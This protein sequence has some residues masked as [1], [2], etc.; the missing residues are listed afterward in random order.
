M[1]LRKVGED[2][3]TEKGVLDGEIQMLMTP[4]A[5]KE[6]KDLS[7]TMQQ[8]LLRWQDH[9]DLVLGDQL[10][11]ELKD[12]LLDIYEK[13]NKF[14]C[15]TVTD[16]VCLKLDEFIV[17]IYNRLESIENGQKDINATLV[18][19]NGRMDRIEKQ[20]CSDGK[21][22][23]NLERRINKVESSIKEIVVKNRI[24]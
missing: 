22:I 16:T 14:L 21:K 18:R 23:K 1:T 24:K 6:L 8:F 5:I 19:M 3:I 13:D 7:P 12:F 11:E 10:K 17:N 2:K 4:S 20:L 15:R 9:R